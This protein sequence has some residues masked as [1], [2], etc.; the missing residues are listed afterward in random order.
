MRPKY[1]G[2]LPDEIRTVIDRLDVAIDHMDQWLEFDHSA[3][4]VRQLLP[5]HKEL[6][7]ARA[8][9]GMARIAAEQEVE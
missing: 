7:K 3:L 9:L 1:T 5:A 2:S 6:T 8:T 4:I